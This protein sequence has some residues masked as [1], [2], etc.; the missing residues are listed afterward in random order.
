MAAEKGKLTLSR[1]DTWFIY[2]CIYAYDMYV[3]VYAQMGN[4]KYTQQVTDK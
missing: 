4:I 2:V 1:D 3:H